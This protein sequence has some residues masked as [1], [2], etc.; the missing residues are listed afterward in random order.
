MTKKLLMAAG[1]SFTKDLYQHTWADYLA[2]SLRF[3][4]ENIGARGAGMQFILKRIIYY[5]NQNK[6]DFAAV[7]LTS[8]DRFDLYVDAYHPLKQSAI[9]LSSWQ[10]G[11][12][13]ALVRLD[14]SLS[15]ESGYSL[16][17]GHI[18]DHKTY[19]YKNYYNE[20]FALLDYWTCVLSIQNFFK[21][22]D[23]PYVF[24]TAYDKYHLIDQSYNETGSDVDIDFLFD[25]LDWSK[26]V[27]YDDSKGLLSF[28]KDKKFK[29]IKGHPVADAHRAYVQE[30]LYPFAKNSF[31]L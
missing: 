9:D 10:D 16:S 6:P 25:Q 31:N 21:V 30:I 28:A 23:I 3:D 12:Q 27:F 5:C 22:N 24:T 15:T 20:S 19:W 1:C 14:G 26:F 7:M 13:P 4:L 18:R 8:M 29:E 11:R 2:D 17:G